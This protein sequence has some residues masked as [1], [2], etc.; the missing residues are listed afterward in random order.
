MNKIEAEGGEIAIKNSNGDIAIVPKG[1][2]KYVQN[3]IDSGKH[4]QVD[5]F[6]SMLPKMDHKAQWGTVVKKDTTDPKKTEPKKE[7]K[8]VRKSHEQ[9]QREY[10]SGVKHREIYLDLYDKEFPETTIRQNLPIEY[11]NSR[12]T[13]QAK[14]Y[15]D[16]YRQMEFLK[17]AWNSTFERY[18]NNPNLPYEETL[19]PN[20][21]EIY[22]R[23]QRY[24]KIPADERVIWGDEDYWLRQ[25]KTVEEAKLRAEY[26][27]YV[28][29]I[30]DSYKRSMGD[31]LRNFYDSPGVTIEQKNEATSWKKMIE[32]RGDIQNKAMLYASLMDEGGDVFTHRYYTGD[33]SRAAYSG[34]YSF[35]I[36]TMG[37]RMDEFIKKGYLDP[38]FKNRVIIS[39]NRNEKGETVKSV[40]FTNLNDV[41]TAKEAF[42]KQ[43]RSVVDTKAKQLGINLSD[44]AK[45]YF[46][47]ITY[48]YGEGGARQMMEAYKKAGILEND[49]FMLDDSYPD[50]RQVHRNAKRRIQAM[51]MVQG[52]NLIDENAKDPRLGINLT[53]NKLKQ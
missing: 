24:N 14:R 35:G 47:L 38:D 8:I 45:D 25:G 50:Y 5:A 11:D 4:D 41:V 37:S 33:E 36:D 42:L 49:K 44:T 28:R 34:F 12:I 17:Q 10:G 2:V 20:G 9:L 23:A 48:N 13:G 18:A 21:R 16:E 1:K 39:E 40:D 52:E 6:V 31:A 15:Q 3:L 22:E 32:G 46:T 43:G 7:K 26:S 29:G 30:N 53:Q 51:R 19:L 27:D